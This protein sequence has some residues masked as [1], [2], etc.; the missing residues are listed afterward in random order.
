MHIETKFSNGDKVY[1]ATTRDESY[2]E[3][4]AAGCQS[5]RLRIEGRP[6]TV[7]CPDCRGQG[8]HR[9]SK[10]APYASLMT[11]G[12]V[13]VEIT[14][15][16]GTSN[17]WGGVYSSDGNGETN[18]SPKQSREERYMCI[19]TGIGCGSLYPVE[20]LFHTEDEAMSRAAVKLEEWKAR[21]AEDDARREK[22]RER[23]AEQ[24][25]AEEAD[26]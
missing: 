22:E 3:P 14:D 9:R 23:L 6:M 18:Y 10:A 7:A 19:E 4:C 11:I 2:H 17:H 25:R 12:R 13:G 15:S 8:Y 21:V 1:Y 20:D 26:A 5:G 24:Y 16:P